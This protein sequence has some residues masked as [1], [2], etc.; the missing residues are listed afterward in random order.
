M[1]NLIFV[2]H[3]L[4]R[5]IT[6]YECEW[7]VK[8]EW[9]EDSKMTLALNDALNGYGNYSYGDQDQITEE[10]AEE[11]IL[12]GTIILQGDIGYGT[13]Y[14]KPTIIQLSNWRKTNI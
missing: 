8:G 6:P 11:L 2:G 13:F 4:A 1:E 12:K 9:K 5:R 3:R 7:L 10:M 14:N